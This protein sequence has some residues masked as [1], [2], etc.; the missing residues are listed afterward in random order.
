MVFKITSAI[1]IFALTLSIGMSGIS[2]A[3]NS[4]AEPGETPI[5]GGMCPEGH[6]CFCT[7]QSGV[8]HDRTAQMN[9]NMGCNGSEG[10]N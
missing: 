3:G 9:V 4:F 2:M 1:A 7:P 8:F 10:E 5:V 6:E